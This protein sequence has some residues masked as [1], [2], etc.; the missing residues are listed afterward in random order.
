MRMD[1]SRSAARRG[2]K[3]W[4]NSRPTAVTSASSAPAERRRTREIPGVG[5]SG[6]HHQVSGLDLTVGY[7]TIQVDRDTGTEQ[8]TAFI[9]S[10]EVS[11]FWHL[12]RFAPVAQKDPVRLVGH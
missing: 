7:R 6:H 3:R 5:K 1:R 11:C 4:Q 10:I 8:V 2:S 12:E 9:E